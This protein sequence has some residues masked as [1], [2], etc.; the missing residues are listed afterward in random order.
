VN[1]VEASA[2][3]PLCGSTEGT[4]FHRDKRREYQ[5]CGLCQLVYVPSQYFPDPAREKAEYDLHTNSPEDAAYRKFLSR[6]G[7]PLC[8]RLPAASRGL[9]FGCGPG[10]TLSVMLAEAGHD[11]SLYD[12]FYAPDTATLRGQYDFITASEVV[13]HLQRPGQELALLWGLLRPGGYL[14]LMTKLVRDAQAFATWHYKN[15]VTHVCFFSVASWQWWRASV[16]AS[17]EILGDDVILLQKREKGG[18][19]AAAGTIIV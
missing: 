6:L 9:D 19:L 17:L 15:D 5:R 2:L 18:Q 10:P 14:G 3:C 8:E 12:P 4:F 11:I 13:E 1:K 7:D 16:G